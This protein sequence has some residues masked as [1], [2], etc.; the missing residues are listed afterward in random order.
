MTSTLCTLWIEHLNRAC[1]LLD[2]PGN[3]TLG[4]IAGWQWL[5]MPN[6]C[7]PSVLVEYGLGVLFSFLFFCSWRHK[8][9]HTGRQTDIA[10]YMLGIGVNSVN[11]FITYHC[12]KHMI[13]LRRF[14]KN[15][16]L[17]QKG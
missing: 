17:I 4:F 15:Y 2:D 9:T 14:F 5:L 6:F 13:Y 8:H 7:L 11:I 12:L 1:H 16:I 10:T 3:V